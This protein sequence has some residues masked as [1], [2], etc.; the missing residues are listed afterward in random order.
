MISRLI[1]AVCLLFMAPALAAAQIINLPTIPQPAT[2]ELVGFILQN[3]TSSSIPAGPVQMGQAFVAGDLPGNSGVVAEVRGNNVPTQIDV[4]TK[5]PDGSVRF[6]VVTML[7]PSIAA[8][9]SSNA[10]LNPASQSG[11]PLSLATMPNY[12]VVVTLKTSSNTY[13]FDAAKL[14]ATELT[15]GRVTYWRQGPVVTEGR[16]E[17]PV[18]SSMRLV[19]DVSK[20]A[21]GT[22]TTDVHFNNDHAM[23]SSGDTL[24]YTATIAQNGSTVY[25]SGSLTHHQYQTWHKMIYSTG[26]ETRVNVQRDIPYLMSTGAILNFETSFGVD[27]NHM[28]SNTYEPLGIGGIATYMPGTGGRQDIGPITGTNGAWLLTQSDTAAKSALAQADAAGSVPWHYYD[29]TTKDYLSLDKYPT[30]WADGR[31]YPTLTQ[32]T[33]DDVWS[34][35]N[36]HQPALSFIP[37]LFTGSRYHLDQINA[38]AS[39]TVMAGWNAPRQDGLGLVVHDMNQV[40]GA[41]WDLRQIDEAAWANPD[42][43]TAKNYWQK[44]LNNNLDH[45]ISRA[46][47]EGPAQGEARGY[48]TGVDGDFPPAVKPWQQDYLLSSLAASANRGS[49]KAKQVVGIMS[50]YVINRYNKMN[51]PLVGFNYGFAMYANGKPVTTWLGISNLNVEYD[52]GEGTYGP[53]GLMSLANVYNVTGSSEALQTY[54]KML[55]LK[56]KFTDVESYQKDFQF[57]VTPRRSGMISVP[58][59]PIPE[60]AP[61][62]ALPALGFITGDRI[63]LTTGTNVRATANGTILGTQPFGALGTLRSGPISAGGYNWWSVDYDSGLDGYSVDMY[64]TKSSASTPTPS[65]IPTLVPT[66]TLSLTSSSIVRGQT[67]T[68]TWS[69]ANAT[70]CTGTGFTAG[71][72]AGSQSLSPE[73]TTTYTLTCTGT[74]GSAQKSVVVA[75]SAP[76]AQADAGGPTGY[77]KCAEEGG[78]CSFAGTASVAYGAN[79]AFNYRSITASTACTNAVFGD[80]LPGVVKACYFKLASTAPTSTVSISSDGTSVG[81]GSRSTLITPEGTWSFGTSRISGGWRINLNGKSALLTGNRMVVLNGGKLYARNSKGVWYLRDVAA[82]TWSRTINP[83]TSLPPP[84]TPGLSPDGAV[85]SVSSGGS[86]TTA[87]GTWSFSTQTVPGGNLVL[88]NGA[89]AV[90]GGGVELHVLNGGK[91]YTLNN[92]SVWYEYSNGAWK[93]VSDPRT[94]VEPTIV[95]PTSYTI[96]LAGT[97]Q[98][99]LNPLTLP[100]VTIAA[101]RGAWV[102]RLVGTTAN[103]V[104]EAVEFGG[105]ATFVSGGGNDVFYVGG[106]EVIEGV[107]V[108]ANTAVITRHGWGVYTL[109]SAIDTIIYGGDATSNLTIEGNASANILVGS[110]NTSDTR[111]RINGMGGNDTIVARNQ[112]EEITVSSGNGSDTIIGFATGSTRPDE[113]ILSSGAFNNWTELRAALTQV[114][115]NVVLTFKNGETLT[116]VNKVLTDFTPARFPNVPASGS[117]L[118]IND[119][120][121]TI[122]DRLSLRSSGEQVRVLQAALKRLGYFSGEATGY[123]GPVTE[124]A[125]RSFQAAHALDALGIVGPQTR[126]LLGT[127][128]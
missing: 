126:L 87:A 116:F 120:R 84:T 79:G 21:D 68:L 65:P 90:G 50:N 119:I 63:S 128:Q 111:F 54:D 60:P 9:S 75:V 122:S 115:S 18:V 56:P 86:L 110:Q 20:F 94:S 96:T 99:L 103:D 36:A 13:T 26:Q 81:G 11:T 82:A 41:G 123:F 113:I 47:A 85:I 6:G 2:G 64:M 66:V 37:Y 17:V 118:G 107:D 44:I 125:V 51:N 97:S 61:L 98:N 59:T 69:S 39:W 53:S 19:F 14:L 76:V 29:P 67:T 77:T 38:Q 88:L 28:P 58:T 91:L 89:S 1:G 32:F 73:T 34:P 95:T 114:G 23:T 117:V 83:E 10:M 30:L 109:P 124:A 7:A 127:Q 25:N 24:N 55:A 45:L 35:E 108:S 40:R 101:E 105:G 33:K 104:F 5:Y 100:T 31:G 78:T 57:R 12:S 22:Y 112:A 80:P 8:N 102:P 74:G 42:G 3:P 43:T 49:A 93:Q 52:G 48:F 46:A 4:K 15:A 16:F 106:S 72:T 92:T 70:A 62:P 121:F 71:A 27:S